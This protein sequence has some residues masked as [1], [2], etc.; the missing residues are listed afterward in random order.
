MLLVV[1][2]SPQNSRI[3]KFVSITDVGIDVKEGYGFFLAVPIFTLYTTA[4]KYSWKTFVKNKKKYVFELS[5]C[6]INPL[7]A[8]KKER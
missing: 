4:Q 7:F 1:N 2:Y 6:G 5:S 8:V 3:D